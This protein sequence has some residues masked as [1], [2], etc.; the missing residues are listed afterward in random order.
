LIEETKRVSIGGVAVE[1]T[2]V[3]TG[4]DLNAKCAESAE[5]LIEETK[6]VSIGGVA[7]EVTRVITGKDL[8]AK[9]AES[10]ENLIF[11]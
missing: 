9:C 10:A 8:N 5:D 4:K 1:V 3:I 6:R 11:D 2:R 7:V